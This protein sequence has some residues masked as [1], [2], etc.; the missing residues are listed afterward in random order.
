M[1][2]PQASGKHGRWGGGGGYE[3]LLGVSGIRDN[4]IKGLTGFGQ[5]V[6]DIRNIATRHSE[7]SLVKKA[8][9]EGTRVLTIHKEDYKTR[10]QRLINEHFCMKY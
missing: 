8:C 3:A 7:I 1:H 5:K 10:R 9:S 6:R 2:G 4:E